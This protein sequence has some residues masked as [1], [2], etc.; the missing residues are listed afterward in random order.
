ML[1]QQSIA[2]EVL[3]ILEVKNGGGQHI[4]DVPPTTYIHGMLFNF[5]TQPTY[6]WA[7][8]IVKMSVGFALLR[9]AV[10][11]AWRITIQSIMGFMLFYTFGC[12]LVSFIIV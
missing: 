8:C 11:R 10:D 5:A 1:M 6:L 4:S 3:V 12:F 2:G 7:I 9:I